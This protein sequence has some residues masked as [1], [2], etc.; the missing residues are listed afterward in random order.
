MVESGG[1]TGGVKKV[2][3]G[4]KNCVEKLKKQLIFY[5]RED[6]VRFIFFTN[7]PMILLMYKKAYYNI[8]DLDH[9]VLSVV[10]YLL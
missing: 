9:I 8:S 7:R 4:D 10:I 1:K 3:K 5:A 2:K 6:E